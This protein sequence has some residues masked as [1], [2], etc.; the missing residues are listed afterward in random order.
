[1]ATVEGAMHTVRYIN[2]AFRRLVDKTSGELLERP[3]ATILQGMDGVLALLD[4]VY[5]TGK[6]ECHMEQKFPVLGSSLSSHMAWPLMADGRPVGVMIQVIEASPLHEKTVA[7]NEAL[8]LGSLRQH[9][10]TAV[11]DASNIH[12]QEEILERE[13]RERDAL[14]LTREVSHRIKNSLQI[15]V[16]LIAHEIRKAAEPCVQGYTA[17]QTRILAISELY[18]LMSRSSRG[19][20]V[21]VGAYLGEIVRVISESLLGDA[22]GITIEVKADALDIDPDRAVPFGLLANELVTNAIRHAFPDGTGRVV[23]TVERT[24][25]R[26]EF[27][28][29]DDGVGPMDQ[30]PTNIAN[31]HGNDYVAIFVRQLGGTIA[32]L[33]QKGTGTTVRIQLPLLL[34]SPLVP[35][36]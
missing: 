20:T 13:Q 24:G 6:P 10:L 4:R 33:G 32:V 27:T 23:L 26:I 14:M 9:E 1:M 5:R 21:T 35:G 34:A 2:P 19:P 28:V 12:L 18:G 3:L 22:S 36:V 7:M 17:I 16:A 8:M 15:I 31:T 25:D 29:A 30:R 11:A